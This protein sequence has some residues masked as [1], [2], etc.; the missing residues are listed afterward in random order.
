MAAF[1]PL[2]I[3][4]APFGQGLFR[5]TC[6]EGSES[7]QVISEIMRCN[8]SYVVPNPVIGG[9]PLGNGSWNGAMGELVSGVSL[10]DNIMEHVSSLMQAKFQ[11]IDCKYSMSILM[12]N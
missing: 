11:S 9:H 5:P 6:D 8:L 3:Q 2:T 7:V 12:N 1:P 10:G 4:M